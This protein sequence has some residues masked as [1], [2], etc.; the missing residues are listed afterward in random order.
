MNRFQLAKLVDWAGTLE[1][2]KRMQKV[3]YML[4]A[5]GCP[6]LVDF[7]LHRYGPYSSEVA[8]LTDQLVRD[9]ILDETETTNTYGN[10]QYKYQLSSLG[11][12]AIANALSKTSGT[13]PLLGHEELA[14]SLLL[15][16]LR[17]IEVA[18]TIVFYRKTSLDWE[19]AKQKAFQFKEVLP[20]STEATQAEALARKVTP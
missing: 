16:S 18:S 10:S 5:A 3:V 17:N 19:A 13:D 8:S 6:L 20:N 1:S 7:Y 11:Q 14:K 15:E 2:R 4:Q 9:G 12:T